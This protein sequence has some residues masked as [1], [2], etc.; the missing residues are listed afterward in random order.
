MKVVGLV[1][2]VLPRA[3]L[4]RAAAA[5]SPPTH[6]PTMPAPFP[7]A[8]EA[9]LKDTMLARARA[10]CSFANCKFTEEDI[11]HVMKVAGLSLEQII[12]WAD[13]FRERNEV[14]ER[15][16]VLHLRRISEEVLNTHLIFS[17]ENGRI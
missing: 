5:G 3:R 6:I 2:R 1:A 12:K 4:G 17:I 9:C 15:E 14:S 10:D 8:T 13:H 7:V 11:E 16:A